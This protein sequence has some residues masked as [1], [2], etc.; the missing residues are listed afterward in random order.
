MGAS[1]PKRS[2]GYAQISVKRAP[3][4]VLSMRWSIASVARRLAASAQRNVGGWLR[5]PENALL[6][7]GCVLE[8]VAGLSA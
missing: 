1:S 6:D 2:V 5:W 3:R 8:E 7:A 4:N